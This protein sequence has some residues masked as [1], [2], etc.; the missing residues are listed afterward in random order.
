MEAGRLLAGLLKISQPNTRPC[1]WRSGRSGR[2]RGR[3]RI[4][5]EP[6]TRGEWICLKRIEADLSRETLA[7]KLCVGD[8]TVRAWENDESRP[9]DVQWRQLKTVLAER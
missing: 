6:K 7:Q 1:P 9:T 4:V 8:L 3:K 5:I 2:G